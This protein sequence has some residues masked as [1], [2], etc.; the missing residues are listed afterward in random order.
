VKT[1]IKLNQL[2]DAHPGKT[3]LA[4]LAA[5]AIACVLLPQDP[6]NLGVIHVGSAT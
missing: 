5:F 4:I 6:P 1:F 3:L 2:S